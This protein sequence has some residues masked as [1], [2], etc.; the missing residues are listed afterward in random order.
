MNLEG[1][2]ISQF[3][4]LLNKNILGSIIYKISMPSTNVVL[5]HLRRAKD[6]TALVLD[7]N[8]NSPSLYFPNKIPSNPEIPPAFCMLLR[9]HLEEGRITKINQ[10]GLD[11]ILHVEIDLLGSGAKIITKKLIIELTGKNA[12]L[13]LTEEEI[14][15]DCLK[16][17]SANQNSYRSM[18][19]GQK[20]LPPPP[21]KGLPILGTLSDTIVTSLPDVVDFSLLKALI[22]T[23]AGIGKAS[24]EQILAG[25]KIPFNATFLAP[26]DRKHLQQSLK[27]FQKQCLENNIFTVLISPQNRCQTIFPYQITFTP[28]HCRVE[29]FS[30]INNAVLYAAALEPLQLP[31]HDVLQRIVTTEIGKL[32]KKILALGDDL[33]QAQQADQE[34]ILADTL[35]ANI[36]QIHQGMLSCK[37]KNIYDGQPLEIKLNPNLSPAANAQACYRR[38]NKLKRAQEEVKIQ[39]RTTQDSLAYLN[40]IDAS[41]LT[42][43]SRPEI[44]E[45]KQELRNTGIIPTPRK[46][47]AAP[48]KSSPLIISFTKE[49]QIYIG[50]NNKQNDYVTF[51][52]GSANDFWLHTKN[53]PGSHVLVKTSLNTPEPEALQTAAMLAAY[54]S[55]GRSGSKIPVDCTMRRYV[56]KPAGSKPGFV[57]YTHQVT[58]YTTPEESKVQVFLKMK[59][60]AT[61]N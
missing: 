10:V 40:S 60:P 15:L 45:I 35:M 28:A 8:G 30:D 48:G 9:K 20:Y 53:I 41:L 29:F 33:R 11:R 58:Y 36:Y 39:L 25:A 47:Q 50:K 7:F 34:R 38:Y 52:I 5:L 12:N 16:H 13:I 42:A 59:T 55:K 17:I 37:L 32:Q 56:K 4:A 44:E 6:T 49:T 54:F 27:N 46:K 3:A 21:Q 1:I 51:K 26:A 14:I 18:V 57:I 22:N 19:P 31:E 43:T 61:N 24:A 2:V 23:T